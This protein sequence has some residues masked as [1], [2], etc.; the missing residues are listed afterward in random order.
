[1]RV[2]AHVLNFVRLPLAQQK[3]VKLL[4]TLLNMNRKLSI[5]FWQS[6]ATTLR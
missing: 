6:Q 5:T 1:M 2:I 3:P 4:L